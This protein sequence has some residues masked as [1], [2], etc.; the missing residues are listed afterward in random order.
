MARLL[1]RNML[2]CCVCCFR[3]PWSDDS[4]IVDGSAYAAQDGNLIENIL[5]D[6][7]DD[8]LEITRRGSLQP[9]AQSP[10]ARVSPVRREQEES[11]TE[12]PKTV[13]GKLTS[14]TALRMRNSCVCTPVEGMES[15]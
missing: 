15:M 1:L 13:I 9:D 7:D 10:S 2:L 8:V 3:C 12:G 11:A 6:G 4:L 5:E 14:C